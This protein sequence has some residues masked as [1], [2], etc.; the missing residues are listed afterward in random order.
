MME[1]SINKNIKDRVA[2]MVDEAGKK[3]NKMN[4]I[5]IEANG[6]SGNTISLLNGDAPDPIYFLKEVVNLKYSNSLMIPQGN[7]AVKKLNGALMEEFTLVVEGAIATKDNGAYN[8]ISYYDGKPVSAMEEVRKAADSA[9]YILAVGTCAAFGGISAAK[10]NLSNSISVGEFLNDKKV[11][12]LPGCPCQPDWLMGTVSYLSLYGEPELDELNRPK[13]FY[14]NTI[15][16]YCERRSFFE[17]KIFASSVGDTGCFF[18]IGCRGP[19]T[20]VDCPI[21]RWNERINWPIGDNTPCIG[22]AQKGFPDG[23]MPFVRIE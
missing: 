22:C 11:I 15:H 14:G 5:W 20:R 2:R 18:K 23:M 17:R 12:N 3:D 9:K 19:V 21:R 8:Y 16:D 7:Q 1:C 10:P 4:L 13:M 6:C